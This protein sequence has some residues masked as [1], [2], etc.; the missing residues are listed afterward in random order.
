MQITIDA[1]DSLFSQGKNNTIS[2]AG[3]L[4]KNSNSRNWKTNKMQYQSVSGYMP[5]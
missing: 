1:N 4:M 2:N 5:C 3:F